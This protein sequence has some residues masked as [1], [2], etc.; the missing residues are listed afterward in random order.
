MVV[1]MPTYEYACTN[2]G[3]RFDVFQRIDEDSLRICDVCGGTLRKVFH[4][5][6]IVF[7]GSGFYATDSRKPAPASSKPSADG[8]KGEK[9]GDK[10]EKGE[11]KDASKEKTA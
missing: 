1:A 10:S 11:K 5:A 7:K 3:N 9:K 2:C 8:E 6:G 4:P